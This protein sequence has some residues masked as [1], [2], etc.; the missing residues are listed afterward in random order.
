MREGSGKI[1]R[2]CA[3]WRDTLTDS[4]KSEQHRYAEELLRLLGWDEPAAGTPGEASKELCARPYLLRAAGQQTLAAYFVLPGT[5]EPPSNVVEHGLDFCLATRMLTSEAQEAGFAYA[6][7]TDLYRSYLYDLRTDELLLCADEPEDFDREFAEVLRR[8]S[9]ERGALEEVRREPRSTTARRLREWCERW[10]AVVATRGRIAPDTASLVIDRLLVVRYL[11][12][13]NILRRTK[14]RLEQRFQKLSSRA[15]N[16]DTAGL[17]RDLMHLFHDMWFDWRIDLFEPVP[18][19]DKAL[20][21]DHLAASMLSEFA[22]LSRGKF[23]IATILES[24]NHG[25]PREKMLVRIVP[26]VNEERE[27]YLSRQ[28]IDTADDARIEVDLAEEGYRAI[29]YWFDKVVTLYER[30]AVDFDARARRTLPVTQDMDLFAWSEL[31]ADRPGACADKFAYAC[32]KGLRVYFRGPRQFRV[33]RLM[34]T[35]HLINRYDQLRLPVAVFPS[36]KTALEERPV[37]LPAD[38]MLCRTTPFRDANKN[39]QEC[40]N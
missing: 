17:S 1:A 23:S 30:L 22:L 29:F 19:L 26:D 10:T 39:G 20:G 18:E 5:L 24:F 12:A 4:A 37:L 25:D 7:I 38:R 8:T 15:A 28:T 3:S 6:L 33:S 36:I 13:H 35:L 32:E 2:L 21:D 27:R 34:L 31:D 9:V 11:F 16:S 14:W 40:E